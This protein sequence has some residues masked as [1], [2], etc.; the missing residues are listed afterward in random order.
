M[1]GSFDT[2]IVAHFAE[3]VATF[4]SSYHWRL[5]LNLFLLDYNLNLDN[6]VHHER[7]TLRYCYIYERFLNSCLTTHPYH[8][9]NTNATKQ[10]TRVR[11]MQSL[12]VVSDRSWCFFLWIE[13]GANTNRNVSI[14][15]IYCQCVL[16]LDMY[17]HF[18]C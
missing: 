9:N 12:F 7:N 11:L 14:S 18:C 5:F 13:E 16:G 3:T 17:M 2:D 8:L 15:P 10:R 1:G 6:S 4:L